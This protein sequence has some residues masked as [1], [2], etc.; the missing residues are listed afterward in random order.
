MSKPI[1]QKFDDV[2]SNILSANQSV[3]NS[4]ISNSGSAYSASFTQSDDMTYNKDY[5]DAYNFSGYGYNKVATDVVGVI[6]AVGTPLANANKF[7]KR[8]GA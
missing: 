5:L 1:T 4:I 2:T 7:K 3:I 8:Q 6:L